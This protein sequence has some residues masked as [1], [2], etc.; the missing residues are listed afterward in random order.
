[1]KI[2]GGKKFMY[3]MMIVEFE[4]IDIGVLDEFDEDYE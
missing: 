1:M 3:L 4:Y 2:F